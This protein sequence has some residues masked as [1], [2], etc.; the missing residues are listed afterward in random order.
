LIS[1]LKIIVKIHITGRNMGLVNNLKNLIS[2]GPVDDI[3]TNR[4][5]E[6]I[7]DVVPIIKILVEK[8]KSTRLENLL[9]N[10]N[11]NPSDKPFW[12]KIKKFKFIF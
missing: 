7:S 6:I 5:K 3:Q 9:E 4:S 10:F 11:S 12:V 8:L 1:K 2:C